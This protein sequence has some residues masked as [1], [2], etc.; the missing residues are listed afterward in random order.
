MGELGTEEVP[1]SDE[2]LDG[3]GGEEEEREE[4]V[5]DDFQIV[6]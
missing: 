3:E 2:G 1:S 5:E 4:V 6:V